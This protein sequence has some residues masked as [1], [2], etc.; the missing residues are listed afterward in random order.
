MTTGV[1]IDTH[2]VL[3][4]RMEPH[5]LTAAERQILDASLTLFVSA[6]SVWE[7]AMLLGRGRIPGGNDQLLSLLPSLDWLPIKP[8]HCRAMAALPRLHRDPF[9]RMLIAQA[10][11]EQLPLLTRDRAMRSYHAHATFLP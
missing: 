11:S 4:L 7:I 10:Q 2:I 3:W 6:V 9:D 1:L 8:D 5:K